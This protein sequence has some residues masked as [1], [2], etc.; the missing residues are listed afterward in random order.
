LEGVPNSGKYNQSDTHSA[1]A[2]IEANWEQGTINPKKS[3]SGIIFYISPILLVFA[4]LCFAGGVLVMG[5]LSIPVSENLVNIAKAGIITSSFITLFYFLIYTGRHIIFSAVALNSYRRTLVENNLEHGSNYPKV[6]VLIAARNEGMVIEGAVRTIAGQDYP[7]FEILVIDD[8]ST[9]ETPTILKRLA[10]EVPKM[11]FVRRENGGFGKPDALNF[12]LKHASGDIILTFDADYVPMGKDV[13]KR[14]VRW[15]EDPECWAV[16]G[17]LVPY[18][19]GNGSTI[20]KS[21]FC[22]RVGGYMVDQLARQRLGLLPQY[23]GT[24]GGFRKEVIRKLGWNVK[25]LTEDTDLTVRV[26]VNGGKVVY[27]VSARSW[28]QAVQNLRSYWRQRYR[29]ARGHMQC[30]LRYFLDVVRSKTMGMGQKVDTILMLGIYFVGVMMAL[31]WLLSFAWWAYGLSWSSVFSTLYFPILA[32]WTFGALG[33]TAP[34]HEIVVGL[35]LYGNGVMRMSKYVLFLAPL[36][37]VNTIIC[38]EALLHELTGF[39]SKWEKTERYVGVL[40]NNG[41]SNSHGQ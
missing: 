33:N 24:V 4:T 32:F 34:F 40:H 38:C 30:A 7:N 10:K 1:K 25:A 3:L 12:G 37:L 2:P 15:F 26:A 9:D 35:K 5:L 36:F 8:G 6:S 21:V 41:A 27:D 14:L 17:F 29:W 39:R 28:E 22:E 19:T 13:L 16:Q 31:G 11:K 20:A 18:N 23:G